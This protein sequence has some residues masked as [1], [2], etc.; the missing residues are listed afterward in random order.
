MMG[1]TTVAKSLVCVLSKG[2]SYI[3]VLL[4][5]SQLF[6]K[7]SKK[8]LCFF[9]ISILSKRH[10]KRSFHIKIPQKEFFPQKNSLEFFPQKNSFAYVTR[11]GKIRTKARPLSNFVF[12]ILRCLKNGSSKFEGD[13][14]SSL[15]SLI[16][17]H[18]LF[19]DSEK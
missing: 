7:R 5:L 12:Q 9:P 4:A 16:W 2:Y 17:C 8:C 3:N 11:L 1:Y 10:I 6:I 15:C 18:F 14:T 19:H 13:N